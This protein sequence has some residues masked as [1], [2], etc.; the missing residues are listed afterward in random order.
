MFTFI[1]ADNLKAVIKTEFY[2]NLVAGL[3]Q[4]ELDRIEGTAIKTI[5]DKLRGR[6]DVAAIFSA[7]PKDERI[8]EWIANIM[9]YK[10][11]RRQNPR[12][13][14][15]NISADYQDTITWLN[16]IR[17]L[18]EHPDFP[19]LPNDDQ[20]AEQ[21]GANDLRFGSKKPFEYGEF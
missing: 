15:E 9:I 5:K 17:D 12:T 6:Y 7:V 13:I 3:S 2:N 4:T 19:P 11:H 18:R 8:I 20:G 10:I 1:T 21:K 14:P 16:D